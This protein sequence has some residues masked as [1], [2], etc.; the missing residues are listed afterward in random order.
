MLPRMDLRIWFKNTSSVVSDFSA[1][2]SRSSVLSTSSQLDSKSCVNSDFTLTPSL[3]GSEL[4]AG[5]CDNPNTVRSSVLST[6]SQLDS[7]YPNK[8]RS[9][10]FHASLSSSLPSPPENEN[11]ECICDEQ[12]IPIAL[13]KYNLLIREQTKEKFQFS[14]FKSEPP[15][16]YINPI[17]F[18]EEKDTVYL[19]EPHKYFINGSCQNIISVTSFI[20][21]FF[22]PFQGDKIANR[23]LG[24]VSHKKKLNQPS[25][26]YF[27]CDTTCAILFKWDEWTRLGSEMHQNIE[28][29]INGIPTEICE[30]NRIP[31]RQFKQ[32]WQ[33]FFSPNKYIIVGTEKRLRIK[34]LFLAGSPD[35]ILMDRF[36][37]EFIIIDWKRKKDVEKWAGDFGGG[38]C[39]GIENSKFLKFCL[40]L[41]CYRYM[42]EN[43]YTHPITGGKIRVCSMKVLHFHPQCNFKH[44]YK[45]IV[46]IPKMTSIVH[47]MMQCQEKVVQGLEKLA[48]LK[49][50]K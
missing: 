12:N 24:S 23:M 9:S 22:P 6:S 14:D 13:W 50:H 21:C 30:E 28:Y 38:P 11:N 10:A 40:Q 18:E 44:S 7:K 37:L 20:G 8:I 42:L 36:T 5:S 16:L 49:T 39:D 43:F 26:K 45:H 48:K 2:P 15:S 29:D 41:N 4:F 33:D 47:E 25:Y 17:M 1:N 34:H 46:E 32:F 3:S 35:L 27:Q 19:D 31:F